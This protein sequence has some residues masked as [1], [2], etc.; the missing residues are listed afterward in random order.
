[1]IGISIYNKTENKA[2]G[3]VPSC[4]SC[5]CGVCECDRVLC[6]SI[7]VCC[8]HVCAVALLNVG[9]LQR[10]NKNN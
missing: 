3:D 5:H 8:H 6:P 4:W 2:L 1:M 10:I 7:L 9:W